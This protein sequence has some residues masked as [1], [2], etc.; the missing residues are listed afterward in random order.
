MLSFLAQTSSLDVS[1]LG[2]KTTCLFLKTAL[3]RHV[4]EPVTGKICLMFLLGLSV[5]SR[6]LAK[7]VTESGLCCC[8]SS[9]ASF[10]AVSFCAD[11]SELLLL[12]KAKM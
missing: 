10:A 2:T 8:C 1:F 6:L 12:D 3:I 9:M 4:I 5:R 11:P 7:L